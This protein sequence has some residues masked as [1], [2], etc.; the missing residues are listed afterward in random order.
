MNLRAAFF[1]LFFLS[2][3]KGYAQEVA[4]SLLFASNDPLE[5]KL[6]YS[7]RTVSKNKI[8]SLYYPTLLYYRSG[9]EYWDSIK[10]DLQARGNFRRK[11]CFYSPLRI[12]IK[13]KDSKGTIFEGHK[14]LKMVLP[15]E[16]SKNNNI[17]VLKEYLC[18]QLFQ[19]VTPF[20]YKARLV[21]INL[22]NLGDKQERSYDVKAFFIEN[23]GSL[24]ERNGGKMMKRVN[25]NPLLIQD[26]AATRMEFFQYMIS[27]TDWSM[28]T[29][30]NVRIIQIPFNELIPVPYDFDMSGFVDAPYSQ[31]SSILPIT[32]VRDRLY[33]GFCRDEALMEYVRKEYILK[34]AEIMAVFDSIEIQLNTRELTGLKQSIEEFFKILKDDRKYKNNILQFCR[35]T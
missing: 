31:V 1:I 28:I 10:I 24:A 30:H 33:R 32:T 7:F 2:G 17:L 11:N 12:E 35:T 9:D 34:E 5:M 23:N 4:P 3:T 13:K 22:K 19:A 25:T 20:S 16:I 14:N 6:A 29:Q 15:C 8:D 26:T 27:N 18:Y 21:D